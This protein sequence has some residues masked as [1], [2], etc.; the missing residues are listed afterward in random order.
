MCCGWRRHVQHRKTHCTLH[1][2]S[3]CLTLQVFLPVTA[4]SLVQQQLILEQ[5]SAAKSS[6]LTFSSGTI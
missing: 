4:E 2:D 1:Q 5:M 6:E 3:V